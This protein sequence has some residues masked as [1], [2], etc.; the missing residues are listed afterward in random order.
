[1]GELVA[2]ADNFHA[3]VFISANDVAWP[4]A[5]DKQH[6]PFAFQPRPVFGDKSVHNRLM[7]GNGELGFF[8]NGVIKK[9]GNL[10]QT[11]GDFGRPEEVVFH[12]RNAVLLFQ[13][14]T[15]VVHRTVAVQQVELGV[16]GG[17]HFRY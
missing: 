3:Q 15:D 7:T 12:P 8:L 9:G 2:R 4:Q 5:T 14:P 10:A 17:L 11:F 1:M 16:A 6:H 13:M